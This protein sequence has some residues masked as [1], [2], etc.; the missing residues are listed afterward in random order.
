M[1]ARERN[2]SADGK[3]K[4]VEEEVEYERQITPVLQSTLLTLEKISFLRELTVE[5]VQEHFED[6]LQLTNQSTCLKEGAVLDYYVSTFWW[7]K[8]MKFSNEQTS[9]IMALLQSSIDNISEF[10]KALIGLRRTT[11]PDG[12]PPL[13]ATEQAKAITDYFACSLF[14][15]YSMY[16]FL[17]SQSRDKKLLGLERSVEVIDAAEFF[18]PLD[19]GMPMDVHQRYL[20]PRQME[21][22]QKA[23]PEEE[24]AG[25]VEETG[26]HGD[27]E[28]KDKEEQE[29][30]T[31]QEV[32]EALGELAKEMMGTLQAEFT[33]KLRLQEETYSARIDRLKSSSSK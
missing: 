20:A 27:N 11:S 1:A 15:H 8:E 2:K 5:E 13:L 19:E 32:Q 14:Q 21:S 10:G 16:E 30:Y 18:A 12:Y 9:F 6:I 7:T 22:P 4:E 25:G 3:K 31:M 23:R 24:E 28:E 26:G 17:F 29:E 33:E